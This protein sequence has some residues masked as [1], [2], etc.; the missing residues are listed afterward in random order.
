MF[1]RMI[2]VLAI[3]IAG[4]APALAKRVALVIGNGAYEHTIP[5]PNPSNDAELMAAKLRSLGFEVVA[6]QDQ[7]YNDMRRSVLDFARKPM[8]PR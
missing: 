6:G 8:V 3:L 7:T 5:L 2:A 1:T 4:T